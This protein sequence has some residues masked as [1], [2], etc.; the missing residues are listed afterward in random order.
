MCETNSSCIIA[1]LDGSISS[2]PHC[3]VSQDTKFENS[4]NRSDEEVFE[5][6]VSNWNDKQTFDE[7]DQLPFYIEM[8]RARLNGSQYVGLDLRLHYIEFMMARFRIMN[9]LHCG[10][11]FQEISP[12]CDP[13]CVRIFKTDKVKRVFNA[14]LIFKSRIHI[15][16]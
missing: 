11:P 7:G 3:S 6:L 2:S 8:F 14:I 1:D 5:C 16:Q 10:N 9:L 4:F 15:Y 13:R 12:S